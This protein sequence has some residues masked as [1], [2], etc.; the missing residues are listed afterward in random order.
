MSFHTVCRYQCSIIYLFLLSSRTITFVTMAPATPK[1][2]YRRLTPALRMTVLRLYSQYRTFSAT[3]KAFN[4]AHRDYA[5]TRQ[6]VREILK[7]HSVSPSMKMNSAERSGRPRI[8][9]ERDDRVLK[10]VCQAERFKTAPILRSELETAHGIAVSSTTVKRRLKEQ[11]LNG[12]V[13]RKKPN[14][15]PKHKIARLK[16]LPMNISTGQWRIGQRY[17]HYI[18]HFVSVLNKINIR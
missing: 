11:G 17:P 14:L 4:H 7:Q 16:Y 10:R 8:T 13:A 15:T 12:R 1:I 9:S 2:H 5:L 18:C 3:A 6:G